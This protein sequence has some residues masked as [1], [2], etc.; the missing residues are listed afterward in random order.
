[1]SKLIK[2]F[3]RVQSQGGGDIFTQNESI[4]DILDAITPVKV[5]LSESGKSLLCWDDLDE[6]PYKFNVAQKLRQNSPVATMKHLQSNWD[7]LMVGQHAINVG[8]E[9][10]AMIWTIYK[11]GNGE[12]GTE[13]LIFDLASVG[14]E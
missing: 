7:N 6:A 3:Q 13:A 1:M 12:G 11:P 4:A 2:S 8:T 5:K 10:E 9:D 14:V